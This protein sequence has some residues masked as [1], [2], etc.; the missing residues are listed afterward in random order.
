MWVIEVG[1]SQPLSFGRDSTGA[2]YVRGGGRTT[3]AWNIPTQIGEAPRL[4][5]SE[6]GWRITTNDASEYAVDLFKTGILEHARAEPDQVHGMIQF[7][8]KREPT[9]TDLVAVTIIVPHVQFADVRDLFQ[10]LQLSRVPVLIDIVLSFSGFRTPENTLD[11][12]T[13]QQFCAGAP[14][15]IS[16]FGLESRKVPS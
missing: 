4:H 14:F 7:F 9:E 12:P 6:I 8:P 2:Q 5:A 11:V 13:W 10:L 15:P 1:D 16:Q 3:R